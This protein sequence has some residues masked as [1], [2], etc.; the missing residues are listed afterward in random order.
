MAR[1]IKTVGWKIILV[2]IVIS[3][4]FAEKTIGED[5]LDGVD[6]NQLSKDEQGVFAEFLAL[7]W[8]GRVV[9]INFGTEIYS[10]KL[11][12]TRKSFENLSK[13]LQ[14][15]AE[16]QQNTQQNIEDYTG[17]D[18]DEKFGA[19]GVWRRVTNDLNMTKLD[20]CEMEY[21]LGIANE[22]DERWKILNEA[23]E[24]LEQLGKKLS[25]SRLEFLR[26]RIL[27]AL[28]DTDPN[29]KRKA[30][31]ILKKIIANSKENDRIYFEAS[32]EK[33]KSADTNANNEI[34]RLGKE[35][36]ASNFANAMEVVMPLVFLQR[37]YAAA[38]YDRTVTSRNVV[39]DLMGK[40]L[41]EQQD[42]EAKDEEL[43][44]TDAELGAMWAWKD[45]AGKY[46]E[47][48]ERL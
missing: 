27:I 10:K 37:R 42:T 48:L 8:K 5:I 40:I 26:A 4:F 39:A 3:T 22:R 41:L 36:E 24:E 28:S 1:E 32:I 45:G 46:K 33:I 9:W 35:L 29:Y 18:W 23:K 19:T 43:G 17:D 20:L 11:Q 16:K 15:I 12:N 14:I 31:G 2:F 34:Q 21:W 47:A 38:E 6:V 25:S 30:E 7:S 44:V 13:N